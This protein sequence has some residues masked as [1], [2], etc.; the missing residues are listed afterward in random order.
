VSE[1]PETL[2]TLSHPGIHATH[3]LIA[4]SLQATWQPDLLFVLKQEVDLYDTYQQRIAEC[5]HELE[6]H[7]KRMADKGVPLAAD[8]ATLPRVEAPRTPKRRRKAAVMPR[9]LTWA[10]NSTASTAST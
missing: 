1:T 10:A 3:A 8:A 2:A 5:D 4:K 7:V 6:L 9:S